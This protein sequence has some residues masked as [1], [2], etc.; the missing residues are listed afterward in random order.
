[1]LQ[2]VSLNITLILICIYMYVHMWIRRRLP[3][4]HAQGAV[5]GGLAGLVMF[6][7]IAVGANV[8]RPYDPILNM[9]SGCY[10][11]ITLTEINMGNHL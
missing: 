1:M 9:T 11:N 2:G 8:L 5:V 10:P 3:L 4:C 6:M 7:W